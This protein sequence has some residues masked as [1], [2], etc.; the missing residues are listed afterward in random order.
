MI[1]ATASIGVTMMIDIVRNNGI[2]ALE[3][4][5]LTLFT[6]AF[7]WIAI[8]FWN[9]VIGFVLTLIRRDPLSLG[10]ALVLGR[11][12]RSGGSRTALVMPVRNED[13]SR[14]TA[15]LRTMMRSLSKTGQAEQ[16]D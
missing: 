15:G 12:S 10:P 9:A 14:V 3:I 13:P 4:L 8:P 5:I 6:V 11:E 7:S 16:F 2:T 1:F